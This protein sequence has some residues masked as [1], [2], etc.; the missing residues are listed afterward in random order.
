MRYYM[1]Q[2]DKSGV[3]TTIKD[4]D[5]QLVYYI[6]GHLG[7][8]N[9][10]LYLYSANRNRI[11]TLTEGDTRQKFSLATAC[12]TY[13][14]HRYGKYHY[15]FITTASALWGWSDMNKQRGKILHYSHCS[16]QIRRV[17]QNIAGLYQIETEEDHPEYFLMSLLLFDS[18]FIRQPKRNRQL[19]A[20]SLRYTD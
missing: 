16:F 18:S 11:A 4:E 12:Q 7:R 10:T 9:N 14:L 8:P 2:N 20:R 3:W 1:D 17:D 15:H 19:F 5:N 6:A 13:A